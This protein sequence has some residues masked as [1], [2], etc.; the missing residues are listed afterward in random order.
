MGDAPGG[1]PIPLH[2]R[3]KAHTLCEENAICG[4]C[5][6]CYNFVVES[7]LPSSP[8]QGGPALLLPAPCPVSF[9]MYRQSTFVKCRT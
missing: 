2:A 8:L 3:I 1:S 6:E 9:L 5:T 7:G 4:V